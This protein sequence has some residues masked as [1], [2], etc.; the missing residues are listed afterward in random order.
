MRPLKQW[1]RF[2]QQIIRNKI[3]TKTMHQNVAMQNEV[4]SRF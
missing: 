2:S 3:F 4:L 1:S